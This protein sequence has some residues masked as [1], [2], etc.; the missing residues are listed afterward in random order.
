MFVSVQAKK[1]KNLL[2]YAASSQETSLARQSVHTHACSEETRERAAAA[3]AAARA[4]AAAAA[5][6]AGDLQGSLL[7]AG[8]ATRT[9]AGPVTVTRTMFGAAAA[10]MVTAQMIVPQMIDRPTDQSP[11]GA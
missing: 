9:G 11:V 8:A 1:K 10:T 6:A 3:A 4:A 7:T 2:A 5:A